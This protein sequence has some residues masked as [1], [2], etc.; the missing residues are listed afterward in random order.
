VETKADSSRGKPDEKLAALMTYRRARGL[1]FKCGGKWGPQHKCR[2]TVPLNMIEEVWQMLGD[3]YDGPTASQSDSDPDELMA[4][5]DQAIKGTSAPHTLKLHA[6]I[7]KKPLIIL[8]DSSSSHNFISENAAAGLSPWTPIQ[9]PMSV[10]VA[11]GSLLKCTHEV[12]NCSW[13][14]QGVLFTTIFKIIPLQCHDAILE[15][16]W[17]EAF[18]PMQV[19]WK[20]KWLSFPY[21]E[22]TVKLQGIPEAML[23]V[24]E[25]FLNQLLA[26]EKH[27]EVWSIVELYAVDT[28]LDSG[29]L[30]LLL[31]IQDLIEQFSNIFEEPS[32]LPSTRSISHSIPL[33]PG[34][35]PFR[36]KPYRYMPA[37]K[38]KIEK[39]I[40]HFLKSNMI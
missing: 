38:D 34:A 23:P 18:S 17:S 20:E 39:Q 7:Q 15:M 5:S 35:P 33:I 25:V 16:E 32:G 12:V 14:A 9:N 28:V 26:M 22:S 10:K 24:H 19:Q 3:C 21:Q 37:Q 31:A 36:L 1:C 2:A 30:E 6:F 29:Q 8:V 11:D 27:D 13:S 4:L 40:D